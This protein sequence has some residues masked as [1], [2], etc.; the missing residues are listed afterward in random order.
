MG[1]VERED[2]GTVRF[3]VPDDSITAY[4]RAIYTL[5]A[6]ADYRDQKVKLH[7][8]RTATDILPGLAGLD[9]QGF[10]YHKHKSALSGDEWLKDGNVEE[11]YTKEL[12]DLIMKVTGARDAFVYCVAFR[13]RA[14][15][16]IGVGKVE[17]RG[18]E[19]DQVMQCVPRD[20]CLIS[21]RD[22]YST[23]PSRQVHID[24][25]LNGLLETF[26]SC[27]KDITKKAQ[28]II[29]AV[30]KGEPVPRYA[31]FSIWRPLKPVKR[32]P[33]V[34]C[35]TRTN[36]PKEIVPVEF[37]ALSEFEDS[38]TYTMEAL[39]GLPPKHPERQKWYYISEQNPDE[40]LIIKFA[41][42]AAGEDT[43]VAPG[44]LHTSAILEGTED[45]EVRESAEARVFVFW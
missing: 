8:I 7:D 3:T 33:V 20:K 22:A 32:D 10:A 5:P 27:R 31:A 39:M 21:G 28:H 43:G 11:I 24:I 19:L 36:D 17:L 23:E 1:S 30:D 18:G 35:D 26:R 45:E 15:V 14:P 40:V 9:N 34:V 44:A 29:D 41:D 12:R 25:S 16:D 42:S 13:R 2:Y 38:S 4:D 6:N 37:R